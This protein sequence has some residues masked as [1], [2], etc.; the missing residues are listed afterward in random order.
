MPMKLYIWPHGVTAI[1]ITTF[2]L[3]GFLIYKAIET[4]TDYLER[5]PYEAGL[6]YEKTIEKLRRAHLS[7]LSPEIDL[8][9]D[10]RVAIALKRQLPEGSAEGMLILRRPDDE[11]LDQVVVI[12]ATLQAQ[13]EKP[14]RLGLWLAELELGAVNA[15]MLWKK[16]LFVN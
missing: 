6:V 8:N 16:K 9:R 11:S 3:N 15:R 10:G 13:A 2:L 5:N 4:D 1:F 7:G 12:G 14:L